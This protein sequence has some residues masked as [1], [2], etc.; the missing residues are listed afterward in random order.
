MRICRFLIGLTLLLL[1]PAWPAVAA[2]LQVVLEGDLADPLR[3]NLEIALQPPPRL[4]QGDQ[5]N[6][7]WLRRFLRQVPGRAASALEPY[8]YYSPEV[9]TRLDRQSRPPK[10]LVTVDPGPPVRITS[11]HLAIEGAKPAALERLLEK[12]PL[13]VGDILDQPRYEAAK[14]E[15]QAQAQDLGYLDA[16]FSRHLLRVDPHQH[17]AELDLVLTTGPRYRFGAITLKGAE[18]YP[19]GFLRRYLAVQP[20]EPFSYAGLGHTQQQLLDSDRFRRVQVTPQ[21]DRATDGKIPV[22]INLD[23]GPSQQLRPGI[24]YGTDTGARLSTRYQNLNLFRSGEELHLDLLLAQIQQ[25]FTASYIIPH[26]RNADSLFALR[27][28]SLHDHPESYETRQIFVEGEEVRALGGGRT[29]SFYLRY[30]QERS[31]IQTQDLRSESLL[32]GIRFRKLSVDDPVRPRRAYRWSLETRG[33]LAGILSDITLLQVFGDLQAIVPLPWRSYLH[34]RGNWGVT[35][36]T[37]PLRD[38]PAS[39][40]FFAGGDRSVR[41][42][43]YQSLG[44]VD[45]AGQVVGG[46]NLAVGS[47][48]LER[49]WLANWGTALFFDIGN[50]FNTLGTIDFAR[51]AGL[52]LRYYTPVGPLRID[53]ARTIG[54]EHDHYRLHLG[55][56]V[57]W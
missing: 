22:E 32:P 26:E 23:P 55:L 2:G 37:D 50:A 1:L 11:R 41:G 20:G 33:T 54:A 44:P 39:L 15:L 3:S 38:V 9:T 43:A 48:E 40:R 12:F 57:G 5:L 30:Q 34:L 14:A 47:I 31:Q 8:G 17:S 18:R 27:G 51:G 35:F 7:L 56:G 46:K 4:L 53:L 36:Q 25:N 42:Y 19:R 21:R 29:G 45:A 10:L 6:P 24:G 49:R 52:G 16:A 13:K 28:G